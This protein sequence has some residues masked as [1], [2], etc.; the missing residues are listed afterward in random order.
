MLLGF[1]HCPSRLCQ[2]YCISG[3]KTHVSASHDEELP[4]DS[5]IHCEDTF[6]V[7]DITCTNCNLQYVGSTSQP[8]FRRL[9]QH[10]N[11]VRNGR[12]ENPVAV[13]FNNNNCNLSNL[14]FTPFEKLYKDKKLLR[15]R[16][17]YWIRKKDTVNYGINQQY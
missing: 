2:R 14:L 11:D 15:E 13:H 5:N 16:E 7:Y 9:Q 10:I 6:I 17:T 4:I 1:Y 12:F 3:T 8:A